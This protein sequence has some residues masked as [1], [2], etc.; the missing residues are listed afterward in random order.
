MLLQ[1]LA[2]RNILLSLVAMDWC[3]PGVVE[4]MGDWDSEMK[5]ASKFIFYASFKN[6][7]TLIGGTV[8]PNKDSVFSIVFCLFAHFFFFEKN[9]TLIQYR[10]H[11][12]EL[13]MSTSCNRVNFLDVNILVR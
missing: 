9:Y 3:S 8:F 12:L 4:L 1:S 13:K 10:V 11:F 6:T 7:C 2:V 5:R